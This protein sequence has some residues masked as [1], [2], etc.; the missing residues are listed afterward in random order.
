[1]HTNNNNNK[2]KIPRSKKEGIGS[3][4]LCLAY[5]INNKY[6]NKTFDG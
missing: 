3:L 2:Y 6:L 1:M 5:D 4:S